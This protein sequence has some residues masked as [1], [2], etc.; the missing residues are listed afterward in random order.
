MRKKIIALFFS[1]ILIVSILSYLQYLGKKNREYFI[2]NDINAMI[3][4]ADNIGGKFIRYYYDNKHY[5]TSYAIDNKKL[6][7]GDSISKQK[8]TGKFK[9]FYKDSV[10]TYIFVGDYQFDPSLPA[11]PSQDYSWLEKGR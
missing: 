11:V 3:E 7:V 2:N 8:N 1:L 6:Y 5:I 9:V 10:G 4:K